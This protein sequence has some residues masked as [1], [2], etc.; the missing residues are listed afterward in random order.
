MDFSARKAETLR[1]LELVYG[2][3]RDDADLC[4]FSLPDKRSFHP[5]SFDEAA[6]TVAQEC[7]TERNIYLNCCLLSPESAQRSGRGTRADAVAIPGVWVDLDIAG[8]AHKSDLLPPDFEDAMGLLMKMAPPPTLVVSSGHGL[9]GWWLLDGV[10]YLADAEARERATSL[11]EAAQQSLGQLAARFDWTVDPT[12]ELARILRVPGSI[13]WKIPHDPRNVVI[14]YE[15]QDRYRPEDLARAWA[16]AM[17]PASV[18]KPP[19]PERITAG[20][21]TNAITRLAGANRRL[22]VPETA[23]LAAALDLNTSACDPPLSDEKVRQTVA[24]IYGRYQPAASLVAP[25]GVQ[26]GNGGANGKKASA[27]GEFR[28]ATEVKAEPIRFLW[29]PGVLRGALTLLAADPGK[30]KGLVATALAAALTAGKLLPGLPVGEGAVVW[31]SYE[32]AWSWGIKPR[33]DVA[34]ADPERVYRVVLHRGGDRQDERPGPGDLDVLDGLLTQHPEVALIVLDPLVS[35]CGGDI[36]INS[37]NEVRGAL[38]PFVALADRHDVGLLGIAHLNKAELSQILHRVANSIAFS[39]VARSVLAI[40]D[41]ED[42]RRVLAHIKANNTPEFA[43]VPFTIT[44]QY[45]PEID[46]TVG[47]IIWEEPNPEIDKY[48][49]FDGPTRKDDKQSGVVECVEFLRTL[50]ADGPQYV[51]D[52]KQKMTGKGWGRRTIDD[53]RCIAGVL[54]L[55]RGVNARWSLGSPDAPVLTGCVGGIS[56]PTESE[57]DVTESS[58]RA[59]THTPG[60]TPDTGEDEWTV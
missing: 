47:R 13:N 59:T 6:Q 2:H 12:A 4:L 27:W 5:L 16:G 52:V 37:T 56:G 43:P 35:F 17:A 48:R 36:N 18:P 1:F 25:N 41:L 33:L 28:P 32:E 46:Q 34:G 21:R 55:D 45:H 10:R 53:A 9:Y 38:E 29:E 54:T 23:T 58:S 24:G 22:N 8:P 31:V 39:A 14:V 11:V 19:L 50:L 49:I 57:V 15:S 44:G 20:N 26:N 30:G 7:L 60:G 3:H 40:G 42:G 51:K